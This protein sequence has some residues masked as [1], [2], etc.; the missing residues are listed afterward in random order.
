[1]SAALGK[2]GA[3]GA[4]EVFTPIQNIGEEIYIHHCRGTR[5]RWDFG[6]VLFRPK[7]EGR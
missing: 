5:R 3:A 6:D 2:G 7:S 1:M 4:T